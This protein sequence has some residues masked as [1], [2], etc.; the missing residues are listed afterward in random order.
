[1]LQRKHS[2]VGNKGNTS[3][4][5]DILFHDR[6]SYT[7]TKLSEH[8]MHYLAKVLFGYFSVPLA[9]SPLSSTTSWQHQ[10]T[11]RPVS[12]VSW[13]VLNYCIQFKCQSSWHNVCM[14]S[15]K[16]RTQTWS[17][18][19][20]IMWLPRPISKACDHD[21]E[22]MQTEHNPCSL[23]RFESVYLWHILSL[24]LWHSLSLCA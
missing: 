22:G 20:G 19:R 14:A 17:E 11:R 4:T 10:F 5:E 21:E 1:M 7:L 6:S 24:Y 2:C 8:L 12:T 3:W 9:R 13:L 23:A 18:R 15:L 16:T